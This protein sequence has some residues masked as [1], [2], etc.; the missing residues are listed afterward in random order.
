MNGL[1]ASMTS[2]MDFMDPIRE[3]MIN[4]LRAEESP[5]DKPVVIYIDN[6]VSNGRA[7]ELGSW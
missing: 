3:G 6:Q 2:R 7:V 4:S 1:I 5:V